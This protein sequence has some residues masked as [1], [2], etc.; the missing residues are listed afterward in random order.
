MID[1]VERGKTH[2]EAAALAMLDRLWSS[3]VVRSS[4]LLVNAAPEGARWSA[5]SVGGS[6][7]TA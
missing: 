3:D 2:D 7:R 6:G 5:A 4:S 1:R